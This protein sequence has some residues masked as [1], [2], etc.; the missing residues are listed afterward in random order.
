MGSMWVYVYIGQYL[1]SIYQY[2]YS[3]YLACSP[4]MFSIETVSKYSVDSQ[5]FACDI[6]SLPAT[7]RCRCSLGFSVL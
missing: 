5:K 7:E 6:Q 4:R 3:V 1:H 2:V